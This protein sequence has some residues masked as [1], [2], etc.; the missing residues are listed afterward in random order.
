LDWEEQAILELFETWAP[1]DL[2]H[3][4]LAHRGS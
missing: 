3:R 2:S 4:K 1:V